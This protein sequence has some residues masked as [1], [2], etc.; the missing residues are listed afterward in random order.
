MQS[1]HDFEVLP[2]NF[3]GTIRQKMR[4]GHNIWL[5][6]PIDLDQRV[7]TAFC[8][9]FSGTPHSTIIGAPKYAPKYGKILHT[10]WDQ[11]QQQLSPDQPSH[12][13][14]IYTSTH[15]LARI[16]AR[17]IWSSGVSLKRSCKMLFR[18]VGLRS[19]GPSSQKLWPN[20]IF[21]RFPYCNYNVKL[22]MACTIAFMGL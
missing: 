22:K 11:I 10:F 3:N 19:I 15:I 12:G 2:C 16:W 1:G 9:I 17:Q 6:G 5:E 14:I 4:F 7:S 13:N 8:K 20:Q 21:D 18:R